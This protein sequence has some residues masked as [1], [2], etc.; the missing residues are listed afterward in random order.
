MKRKLWITTNDYIE[1]DES[2]KL[3]IATR[4]NT[5]YFQSF[6]YYLPNPDPILK[7][8][9][10]D[11]SIYKDLLSD[12]MVAG[13]VRDRKSA[14]TKLNF[15]LDN[16]GIEQS[17]YDFFTN[18]FKKYELTENISSILD[19]FLFGYQPCEILYDYE[20]EH[21]VAKA[22]IP[23]PPEWF[24]FDTN[25][26]LRFLSKN[27]PLEGEIV[28]DD[29]FVI[30]TQD[31][32]YNN[33]Y[34]V[35]DLSKCFWP[36]SFKRGG[37][38]F[39]ITFCEKYG[40]PHIIGKLPRSA[41]ESLYK[42]LLSKLENMIQ[43]AV[44]VIPDDSSVEYHTEASNSGSV[45]VFEKLRKAMNDDIALALV[46]QT[47]TTDIG[48]RGSRAAA[49]THFKILES[50]TE[51][52]KKI[53]EKTYN[54]LIK[55]IGK[56]NFPGAKLPVFK[57]YKEEDIDLDLSERDLNLAN[58]K[59]IM[60]TKEYFKRKYG[61]LDDEFEVL[62]PS[63]PQPQQFSFAEFSTIDKA[64]QSISPQELQNQSESLLKPIIDMIKNGDSYEEILEKLISLYPDINTDK[65]E[66][67]LEKAI[68]ISEILGR[69]NAR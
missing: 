9:G 60:F 42:E 44:A 29:K 4:D 53:I 38:K 62:N 40:I 22:L 15:F 65:I 18:M 39:W 51:A 21:I 7:K 13:C 64:L 58:T 27:N 37:Y 12:P 10:N 45:E 47:L 36:V 33:P 2:K 34:G 19:A 5:Y 31:T 32:T 49:E 67:T 59:M 20:N 63:I 66:K 57:L 68:F 54:K 16:E 46:G 61:F 30:A 17:I 50:I 28:P 3:E 43:D 11:I 48:D 55:I 26:K 52:D 6:I 14:V 69:S 35:A 25:G 1:I 23:K 41:E 56:L 24:R 8:F